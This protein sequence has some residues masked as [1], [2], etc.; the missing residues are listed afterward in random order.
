M[1]S[2]NDSPTSP[3]KPTP[4]APDANDLFSLSPTLWDR[5]CLVLLE[6]L[7]SDNFQRCFSGTSGYMADG[8]RFIVTVPNPIHQLWIESNYTGVLTDAVI[9]ITGEPATIDYHVASEPVIVTP[10]KA[11]AETKAARLS[12]ADAAPIRHFSEVGLNAKFNFDSFVIGTAY[13]YSVAVARAVAEKPG[14][15]YNPLFFYGSTGLGK[16]HLLQAIGQ[17]VLARKRNANVRYVT[18]EQFTNEF[19]DAIKKQ[20][21]SQF[22][23]KYRKLDV[24]LI[25]DVQFFEGKDS[26]Q[27]EFFHT[28]N[29]LFN[30]AR[31]I[32]LASDRPPSEIKNLESRLVSRFEW[33]LATQIQVPDFETRIAILRRKQI[34]FNVSLDSWILDFMAQHIRSN[35]RKLE[36]ALMRVAAHVSLEGPVN[37]E[38]A[39][40]TLLHDVIDDDKSKAI[41]VDRIQRVVATHYDLRVSDLTGP[42]RPKHIAEGR[43][44]AM[45]LTRTLTKL[46]LVQ[47][48]DEFGGRDHGTV[49][50]ACKVITNL[51]NDS[52]DFRRTLDVLATKIRES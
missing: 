2:P 32:V 48:G 16:T 6:R 5:V 49:I 50:H 22:R 26:T 27:E 47:I 36:G 12:S 45:Y 39:L 33:G 30:N 25:D 17:E 10:A 18:S 15:I 38:S 37:T 42:R 41:T 23:Q 19:V 44:V 29:E 43:Q 24:L 31:Q 3:T 40:G 11:R 20:T 4:N 46:P 52:Q 51:L 9:E 13:S 7:G 21:F 8:G 34:D 28:F 1:E 35:V 14:R